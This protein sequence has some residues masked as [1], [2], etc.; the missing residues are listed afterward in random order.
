MPLADLIPCARVEA[1]LLA[2]LGGAGGHKSKDARYKDA[3]Y[4]DKDAN[5][6]S[7]K[8]SCLQA[9]D[10]T[11][12]IVTPLIFRAPTLRSHSLSSA[13]P[14]RYVLSLPVASHRTRAHPSPA[15]PVMVPSLPAPPS[16]GFQGVR[17][18]RSTP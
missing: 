11:W 4:K 1:A 15:G 16:C 13:V 18:F 5:K 3:N 2:V 14:T 6:D 9:V 8:D 7:N 10:H 12:E 17:V